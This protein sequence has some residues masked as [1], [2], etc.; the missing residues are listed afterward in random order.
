MRRRSILALA[1]CLAAAPAVAWLA[2]RAVREARAR[3]GRATVAG[4]LAEVAPRVEPLWR[5]RAA[6]AGV[7][8]PPPNLTI[9]ILKAER[10]LLVQA[11]RAQ[12]AAFDV[13]AASGTLG[14]K[15][16]QGDLQVPE[17]RYRVESLNPNSRFRLSLRVDYPNAQD[18]A[19]AALDGRAGA[20]LGGDIMIHGGAASIGCVA[21]GDPAVEELF[22][23]VATVGLDRV[24]LLLAPDA[25]PARRLPGPA[26]VDARYRDL[27]AALRD[28]GV[29]PVP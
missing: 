14:P 22:W 3:L 19:D 24:D 2:P 11:G 12:L 27:D 17:G 10:R 25:S 1:A 15:R 26:W 18:R 28:L 29:P 8:F 21:I 7:T 16:L 4:R 23:L 6:D 9:V 5:R 13:T 20:D